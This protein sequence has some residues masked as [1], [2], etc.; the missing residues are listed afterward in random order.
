MQSV[1]CGIEYN[2]YIAERNRICKLKNGTESV[3][4]RMEWNLHIEECNQYILEWN[5]YCGTDWN[6]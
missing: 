1:Y 4:Y 2:L 5:L 6:M 3:Y